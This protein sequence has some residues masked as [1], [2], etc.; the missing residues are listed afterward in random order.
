MQT[1]II[2]IVVTV[3][4]AG[5]LV[6]FGVPFLVLAAIVYRWTAAKL[7]DGTRLALSAFVAALGIA[8]TYDAYMGPLPI[9]VRLWRGEPV[10][11]ISALVSIV[12][13]WIVLMALARLFVRRRPAYA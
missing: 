5:V 4:M 1:A 11:P 13:T 8:P 12:A 9:W 10:A 2:Y 3:L 7:A 6:G